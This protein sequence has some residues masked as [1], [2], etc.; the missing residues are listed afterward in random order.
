KEK[1]DSTERIDST[2]VD[3]GKSIEIDKGTIITEKETTQTTKKEGAKVD[4]DADLAKLNSGET[5]TR[6]S[7]GIKVSIKLDPSSNQLK[8]SVVGVA[9]EITTTI[10]EKIT[11]TKDYSKEDQRDKSES[12]N[13]EVTVSTSNERKESTEVKN[14]QKEG[15]NSFWFIVLGLGVVAIVMLFV[16]RWLRRKF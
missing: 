12:L 8:V 10:K 15:K 13:K 6:D 14:V 3:K 4:V 11:E 7:A 1:S 16:G 5:I 2:S 9:E